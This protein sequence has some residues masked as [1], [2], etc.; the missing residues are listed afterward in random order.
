M[1]CES[2]YHIVLPSSKIFCKILKE[3]EG[4]KI[5]LIRFLH[6]QKMR[7]DILKKN[8]PIRVQTYMRIELGSGGTSSSWLESKE[9]PNTWRSRET[10]ELISSALSG[11]LSKTADSRCSRWKVILEAECFWR[12]HLRSVSA[13]VRI[14]QQPRGYFRGGGCSNLIDTLTSF[15]S[16]F[17]A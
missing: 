15:A 12:S 11:L 17:T 2:Q 5:T 10:T 9:C 8:Q 3:T 1:K 6:R 7:F 16:L 13:F 14:L 4:V